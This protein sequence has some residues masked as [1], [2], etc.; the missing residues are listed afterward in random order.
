MKAT[1]ETAKSVMGTRPILASQHTS[2]KLQVQ[3]CACWD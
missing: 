2:C 3:Y 1:T